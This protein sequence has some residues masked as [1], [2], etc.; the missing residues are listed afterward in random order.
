MNLLVCISHVPDTTTKIAFDAAGTSL[1]TP[2]V[3]YVIG[4]FDEYGLSW[5]VG[6][7]EKNPSA[8]VV[9]LCVGDAS[10]EPTI[11]KALA[12][13]ADEGVRIEGSTRGPPSIS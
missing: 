4:P 1:A 11:R 2:N 13:G 9:A 10:V 12:I 5:A 6:Y 8:K 7:K 3:Q